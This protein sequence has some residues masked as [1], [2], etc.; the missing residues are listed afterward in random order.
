MHGRAYSSVLVIIDAPLLP[1]LLQHSRGHRITAYAEIRKQV[2]RLGAGVPSSDPAMERA[3]SR[4]RL[5]CAALFW[6]HKHCE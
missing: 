2:R 3:R 6:S 1:P 5:T 4:L